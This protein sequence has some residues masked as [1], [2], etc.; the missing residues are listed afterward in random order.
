MIVWLMIGCDEKKG[1]LFK[2]KSVLGGLKAFIPK[3]FAIKV[4]IEQRI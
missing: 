3:L 4:K 2:L 1:K